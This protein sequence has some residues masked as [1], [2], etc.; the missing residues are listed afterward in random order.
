VKQ[1]G[2]IIL[3]VIISVP[4]FAANEVNPIYYISTEEY[5][6][7]NYRDP[8]SQQ[9][10]GLATQKV[11][12]MMR[13]AGFRYQ[14]RLFPWMRAYNKALTGP[15]YCVFSTAKNPEREKKF[16]WIGPLA[17]V[18]WALFAKKETPAANVRTLEE[19]KH[20]V[21]GG[22]EGDASLAELKRQGFR[23]ESV[24][25]NW[26]NKD[27]LVG[28]RI[29]LWIDDPIYVDWE[30]K[31]GTEFFDYVKVL[32]L[33]MSPL[34]LACNIETPAIEIELLRKTMKK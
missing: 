29:Q 5:P 24:V 34:Y 3:L 14:I 31:K 12:T 4:T 23:T 16:Y 7:Y 11:E 33:T 6:P 1:W 28:Q 9:I 8:G 19:A 25:T 15:R 2:L 27:K 20:F 32:R 21:V 13:E 30:K 18:E 10:L 26:L 22:L 17:T